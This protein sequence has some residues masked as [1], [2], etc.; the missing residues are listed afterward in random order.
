MKKI[1]EEKYIK[2]LEEAEAKI[3]S[4]F[5]EMAVKYPEIAPELINFASQVLFTMLKAVVAFQIIKTPIPKEEAVDSF[6]N[7]FKDALLK[8]LEYGEKFIQLKEG[9]KNENKI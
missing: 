6:I 8:E 7:Y 3:L 4:V 5:D 2:I 1:S 9:G